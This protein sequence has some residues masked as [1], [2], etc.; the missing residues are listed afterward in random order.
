M[1]G[2]IKKNHEKVIYGLA[3]LAV[4]LLIAIFSTRNSL[5]QEIDRLSKANTQLTADSEARDKTIDEEREKLEELT[6]SLEAAKAEASKLSSEIEA[7]TVTKA[8]LSDKIKSLESSLSDARVE[9]DRLDFVALLRKKNAD[10]L[11]SQVDGLNR[12]K[13]EGDKV[14]AEMKRE[15][16]S[17]A[18][19]VKELEETVKSLGGATQ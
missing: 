3:I 6:R 2:W 1:N 15:A 19:R 4:I 5:S 18:A 14:I 11:S 16:E 7:H 9:I 10:N 13:T 17:A 8:E 12:V